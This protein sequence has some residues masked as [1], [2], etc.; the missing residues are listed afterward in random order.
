MHEL[1]ERPG[2]QKGGKLKMTHYHKPN[3]DI[4]E[5]LQ[6]AQKFDAAAYGAESG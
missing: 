1:A 6:M 3:N 2:G 4:A 5:D